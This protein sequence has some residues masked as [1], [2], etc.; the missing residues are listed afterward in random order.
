MMY[1][2]D[3]RDDETVWVWVPKYGTKYVE[4]MKEEVLELEDSP[5]KTDLLRG[6]LEQEGFEFDEDDGDV[7]GGFT[8]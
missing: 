1:E 2:L 3:F 8:Y 4:Y 5:F 7:V 6:F